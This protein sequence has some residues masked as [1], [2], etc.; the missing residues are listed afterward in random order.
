VLL[1]TERLVLR[2]F[3]AADAPAL[4]AYRSDEETARYQSWVPPFTLARAEDFVVQM[5]GRE[6]D[7]PGWF[8]WAVELTS[9][10]VLI[11]DVGVGLHD[12]LMQADLGFTFAPAYRG[13]GY[14]TEAVR[15]VLDRVF[16]VQGVRRVSAECDARNERSARLLERVGFTREGRQRSSTWLKGEWTDDLLFGLLSEDWPPGAP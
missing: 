5:A 13:Q 10:R 12:N 14:A 2:R 11:G 6:P 8:Q 16:T 3:R 1:T 4:A 15:A 9:Q 7:A